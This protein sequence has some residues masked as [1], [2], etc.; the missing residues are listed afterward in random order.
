MA[1]TSEV[2]VYLPI[3][4]VVLLALRRYAK[5]VSGDGGVGWVEKEEESGG[6]ELVG[7]GC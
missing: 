3:K 5:V 2:C 6:G 4:M 7:C 1:S